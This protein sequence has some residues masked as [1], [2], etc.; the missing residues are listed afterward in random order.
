MMHTMANNKRFKTADNDSIVAT[1]F[2]SQR[3]TEKKDIYK[4]TPVQWRSFRG[5]ELPGTASH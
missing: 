5:P 3:T 1:P 2:G 4:G